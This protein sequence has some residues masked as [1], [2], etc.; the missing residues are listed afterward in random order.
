L[1]IHLSTYSMALWIQFEGIFAS[2]A[3]VTS[4]QQVTSAKGEY[5]CEKHH[6]VTILDLLQQGCPMRENVDLQPL[7]TLPSAPKLPK[8]R[9]SDLLLNGRLR[10]MF[11]WKS[12]QRQRQAYN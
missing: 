12:K 11:S 1:F 10:S 2:R 8:R 9:R 3:G 7:F 6:L 5:E 4:A